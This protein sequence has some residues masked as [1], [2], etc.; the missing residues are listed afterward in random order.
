MKAFNIS[1]LIQKFNQH[2]ERAPLRAVSKVAKYGKLAIPDLTEALQ[3][4]NNVRI[5][6]WSAAALGNIGDRKAI[7]VLRKALR[8]PNMSVKL[9]AVFALEELQ[10]PKLGQN[11]LPLLKDPSGGIRV[12]AIYT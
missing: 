5:R 10:D 4:S 7:P 11:L 12:N 2:G 3:K 6:R 8:D 9:R 1:T